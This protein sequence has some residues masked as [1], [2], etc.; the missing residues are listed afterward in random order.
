MKP[1]VR[2]LL[3]SV[4]FCLAFCTPASSWLMAAETSQVERADEFLPPIPEGKNWVLAWRDEFSGAKL[5]ES[6]W[7]IIGDS[8]RR[9]GYWVKEDSYLDGKGNLILRTK[10]DGERF[11]SGAVRT[12]G[13]FEHAFG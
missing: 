6:K 8:K 11:T 12:R 2:A 1:H 13:K 3:K 10:K 9:D 7:E 4:V 5:D